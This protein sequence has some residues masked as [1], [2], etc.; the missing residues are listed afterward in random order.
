[1]RSAR[2]P[3]HSGNGRR[4]RLPV[5]VAVPVTGQGADAAALRRVTGSR[6][7]TFPDAAR[8]DMICVAPG[9]RHF[10]PHGGVLDSTGIVRARAAGRGA[11]HTL[12]TQNNV[13]AKKTRKTF[14]TSSTLALAA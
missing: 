7:C 13:T 5:W 1:M 6:F 8:C 3:A 11:A 4:R 9:R 14:T 2:S 10:T 12:I